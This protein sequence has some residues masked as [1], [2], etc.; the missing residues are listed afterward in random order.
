MEFFKEQLAA[1]KQSLAWQVH[2]APDPNVCS[3]KGA[4]VS[5]YQDVVRMLEGVQPDK[6]TADVVLVR[7]GRWNIQDGTK[8]RREC[9]ACGWDG[10]EYIR[11]YGYYPNCVA[12]MDLE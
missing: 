9:S 11:F 2:N 6:T 4:I 1:A 3:E 5:F 8:T 12:M 10:P 7:H